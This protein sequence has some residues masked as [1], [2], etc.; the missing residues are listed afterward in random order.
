MKK[1]LRQ[2]KTVYQLDQDGMNTWFA[3]VEPCGLRP[4]SELDARKKAKQIQKASEMQRALW[5]IAT[6]MDNLFIATHHYGSDSDE[7]KSAL[8]KLTHECDQ[9]RS[10][11]LEII[12]DE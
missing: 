8:Q 6:A 12:S 2:D 10:I 3:T 4:I 1:W 5:M 9:G 7:A 11:V